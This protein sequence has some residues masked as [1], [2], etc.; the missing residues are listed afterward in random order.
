LFFGPVCFSG[1][2]GGCSSP[3]LRGIPFSWWC[4][5]FNAWFLLNPFGRLLFQGGSFLALFFLLHGRALG[6]MGSFL[7]LVLVFLLG[8][9]A[10]WMSPCFPPSVFVMLPPLFFFVIPLV[11]LVA[12]GG[13]DFSFASLVPVA[14]YVFAILVQPGIDPAIALL[15]GFFTGAFIGAMVGAFLV[16]FG[17][18]SLVASLGLLFLFRGVLL[19][20]PESRSISFL[21]VAAPWTYFALVGGFYGFPVQI[22]WAAVF[23]FYCSYFFRGLVFGLLL[24]PVG[25]IAVRAELLGSLVRAVKLLAFLFVGV[26]AALGGFFPPFIACAFF[27]LHGLK[28]LLL[29]LAAVF[30][31]KGL[32]GVD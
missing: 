28:C 17:L 9:P 5:E 19:F 26:G 4:Y 31:P 6:V 16:V 32:I 25:G 22:F 10:A 15:A 14:A 3:F 24:P 8:A 27:P 7:L 21:V 1:S 30:V 12:S 18:S 23:V 2:G 20:L 29:A 11:F 13:V